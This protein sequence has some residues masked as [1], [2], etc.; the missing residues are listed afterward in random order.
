MGE[1]FRARDTRLNREVAIKI[2]PQHL[3]SSGKLRERFEREARTISSLKHPNICTLYDVGRADGTDYLVLEYLEGESLADRLAKGPLA[4]DLVVA[5]GIQIAD[6][7]E[8]AHRGGVVHRDLKPGNIMLTKD[9]VKVLDF[10]LAKPM[11]GA[12]LAAS[13]FGALTASQETKPL[14]AEGT[15][16]GTFQYMAP[17]QLEGKEADARSDLFGFGCVLYEMATGKRPFDGKTQASVVASILASEPP[18]ISSLQPLTPPALERLV[19]TCI[20]KDPDER[21]QTAHDLKLQLK[22]IAEGGSQAGVPAP[23]AHHR[24]NRERLAWASGVVLALLVA[25]GF[26]LYQ[27]TRPRALYQ[28]TVMPPEK[29]AFNFRGLAGP[30]AVSP[31]GKR[32]AFVG[33]VVGRIGDRA[34]WLRSLDS[35]EARP[36]SGTEGAIY[37]FWSPDGRFLGFFSGGKLKKIEIATGVVLNICDVAEGRG[38]AWNEQGV[39][40]FGQRDGALLRTTAA[41]GAEPQKV[42][43]LDRKVSQTS[44]RFPYFMP[45]GEHFI[46][47]AQAAETHGF[48]TSLA[49][50]AKVTR[51]EEVTGNVAFVDGGLLYTRESTLLAQPFDPVKGTFSGEPAPIAEQVQVDP[52]FNFSVFSSSKNGVLAF[53]SGAVDVGTRLLSVDRKGAETLL[54]SEPSMIGAL[55]LAPSGKLA[56][57]VREPGGTHT[58]IWNFDPVTRQ[59]SRFTFDDQSCCPYFSPDGSKLLYASSAAVSG[60]SRATTIRLKPAS[61]LGSEQVLLETP[62]EVYPSGWSP[63]GKYVVF[64]RHAVTPQVRWEIWVVPT[65]GGGKPFLLLKMDADARGPGVSPDGKWLSFS[66]RDSGRYE[67]Y[68][69]PFR[70][71][72]NDATPKGKW[73]IS[74][75]GAL[76]ST[77]RKNGKELFF[78]NS[79]YT[80]LLSAEIT[81]Q[82]DN[83]S[84]AAPKALFDLNPHPVFNQFYFP[85]PDGQHFYMTVYSQGSAQPFTV[86]VNWPEKLKQ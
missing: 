21:F 23:V 48:F 18:P 86:T 24:R 15:I 16:V 26:L 5:Y 75:G 8:R 70:P 85:T 81:A 64:E 4:V 34:L 51:L 73:Q 68:V 67:I 83:F 29:N 22:W 27:R 58:N 54:D 13:A 84:A 14:T 12:A 61:G 37:P 53:Q 28:F 19:K 20:A 46:Y 55:A 69:V 59:K 3:S 79:S 36:L 40:L 65:S 31:D 72:P 47:V 33:T 38:G 56:F 57:S 71:D 35:V 77:W 7:L 52:Q 62:D 25:A 60:G 42:T 9:G 17:E 76:Q 6:A 30:P 43:E 63:D 78:S 50:P 39:I 41:G 44:H 10:G 74:S 1:V 80:T 49:D 32:V 45:D 11:A 2:L 66:G 82:G